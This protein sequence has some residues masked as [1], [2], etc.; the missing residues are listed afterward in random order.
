ML[1]HKNEYCIHDSDI[2]LFLF[3]LIWNLVKNF[4]TFD[5]GF[6]ISLIVGFDLA[7]GA[8]PF[9]SL[10]TLTSSILRERSF[11]DGKEISNWF[12]V[13]SSSVVLTVVV[14][15]VTE[16]KEVSNGSYEIIICSLY[17]QFV[18]IYL[19]KFLNNLINDTSFELMTKWKNNSWFSFPWTFNYLLV[20]TC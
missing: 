3:F 15:C 4:F 5:L 8:F 18:T 7:S 17:M 13:S 10:E 11:K 1:L 19:F 16:L 6:F 14:C 2:N 9:S 12:D 20:F